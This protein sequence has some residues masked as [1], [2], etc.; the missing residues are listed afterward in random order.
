MGIHGDVFLQKSEQMLG[1]I[2][3]IRGRVEVLPWP[4]QE[5]VFDVN[6]SP[7]EVVARIKAFRFACCAS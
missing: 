3:E 1:A 5:G 7:H 2:A 6:V 4:I